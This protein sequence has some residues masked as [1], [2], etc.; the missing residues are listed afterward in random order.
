MNLYIT[1]AE[2]RLQGALGSLTRITSG[3]A[4][5]FSLSRLDLKRDGGDSAN[6]IVNVLRDTLKNVIGDIFVLANQDIVVVYKGTNIKLIDDAIYKVLYLISSHEDQHEL[7]QLF[8]GEV[9]T[10]YYPSQNWQDFIMYCER[11]TD[12]GPAMP[13]LKST[14]LIKLFSSILEDFLAPLD[15][16]A[17]F[18]EKLIF[19][20]DT[21][22]P[23]ISEIC[24]DL[25]SIRYILGSGFDIANSPALSAFAKEIIDFKLLIRFLQLI[26]TASTKIYLVR[27]SMATISSQE[28][29]ALID[30]LDGRLAQNIII[31]VDANEILANLL[32]FMSIREH[33]VARNIKLCLDRLD[34]LSF[35]QVGR[36]ALGFDI[37][38]ILEHPQNRL[39]DS[40]PIFAELNAKLAINGSTRCIIKCLDESSLQYLPRLDCAFYQ[41]AM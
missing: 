25:E 9:Y 4:V 39:A 34:I 3:I 36:E 41:L 40:Q 30:K 32:D 8:E 11:M 14:S 10:R 37:V 31:A 28:F 24:Y 6:I 1:A 13:N 29:A 15:W 2:K 21:N 23:V 16:T 22:Q 19:K 33:M 17:V 20:K 18:Q 12:S 5:V 27:L 26:K 35:M 38:R 7:L